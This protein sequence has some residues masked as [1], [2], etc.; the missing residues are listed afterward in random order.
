MKGRGFFPRNGQRVFDKF[1]R[2]KAATTSSGTGIG[3]A[4]TNEIVRFHGGRIWIEDLLP[5]G[6][7]FVVALPRTGEAYER[8]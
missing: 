6:A 8:S 2:G 1:Y 5:Q 4:I 7:R 3:L